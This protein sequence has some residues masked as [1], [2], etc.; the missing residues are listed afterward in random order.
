MNALRQLIAVYLVGLAVV[1]AV[2]YMIVAVY[3][4]PGSEAYPVWEVLN[5]FQAVAIVIALVVHSLRK[6]DLG[7]DENGPVTRGYVGVNLAFYGSIILTLWFF[8]NWLA[9][10]YPH[11]PPMAAQAH[12]NMWPFINVLAVT[13]TG[14]AGMHL[15]CKASAR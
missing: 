14:A 9:T 2:N 3:H 4:E 7:G 12:M 1:V 13:V 15:W 6:R 8:A 11:E 10:F 5:W